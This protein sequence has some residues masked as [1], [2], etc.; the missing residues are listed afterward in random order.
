MYPVTNQPWSAYNWYL[1]RGQSRVEINTD[2]PLQITGLVETI[3]HKGYPGHHTE[4]AI[5]DPRL[6][7]RGAIGNTA[8][9]SSMHRR[10]L[11]SEE[12]AVRALDVLLS[13]EEQIRWHAEEVTRFQA[14]R[15]STPGANTPLPGHAPLRGVWDNAAFLL[16]DQHMSEAEVS[17]YFQRYGLHRAKEA[18]KAVEFISDPLSRSY[19][20]TYTTAENYWMPCSPPGVTRLSGLRVC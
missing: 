11:V 15:I 5:K 8:S 1:G 7:R 16:H 17:A 14:W 13:E 10:A 9:R 2:L 6:L 4:L 19:V 20:F 12:I 18:D 3:A